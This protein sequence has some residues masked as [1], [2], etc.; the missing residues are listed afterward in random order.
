MKK[1]LLLLLP[2]LLL[3]GLLACGNGKSENH[4]DHIGNMEYALYTCPMP[5]DSVF[6][7]VPGRCPKCGMDLVKMDAGHESSA[8]DGLQTLLKPTDEFILSSVPVTRLLRREMEMEIEALGKITYDTRHNGSIVSNITGRIEKLYVRYRFQQV[9]KGQRIMDIYSPELVTAQQNLLFLL[10]N[11]PENKAMAEAAKQ[12][13]LLLGMS[14]KQ[15]QEVIAAGKP[16][17]QVA[18]YSAYSGHIHE[19][20]NGSDMKPDINAMNDISLITGELS[21]K[22]GMYVQKAQTVFTVFDPGRAWAVL[23]FFA[24]HQS[25]IGKGDK[26][27]IVPETAPGKDFRARLDFIEPFFREGDKTLTARVYFDNRQL[28]IPIGSQVRATVF[29]DAKQARWL[30]R[31]AVLSLG[32]DKVVFLKEGNGFRASKLS[33]GIVYND[34]VQVLEGLGDKDEV[35]IN[36]QFLTDSESFIKVKS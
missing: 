9:S 3:L 22:E 20:G 11:D 13:L 18:V 23:N 27:R 16:A 31:T 34:Y 4:A 10:L 12:R 7:K 29:A 5:E 28:K 19:A 26:V 14:P 15:L 35:A 6:S 36:A 21:I 17:Y 2:A 8:D 30:P 32:M 33:T 24:E 1:F 25:L